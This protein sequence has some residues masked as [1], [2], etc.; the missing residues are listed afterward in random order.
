MKLVSISNFWTLFSYCFENK[1]KKQN[2]NPPTKQAQ[3]YK[4]SLF[5]LRFTINI[6]FF[7]YILLTICHISKY[8][9]CYIS[10]L[11]LKEKTYRFT[12][13]KISLSQQTKVLFYHGIEFSYKISYRLSL[14]P[15]SISFYWRWILTN[16]PLDYIFFLYL[17]FLQN[18]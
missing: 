6:T 16:L 7:F 14:Q 9:I 13:I 18:F 8:Q 5:L 12:H 11:F 17:P 3:V 10:R 2:K 1:N 4:L 15:Y